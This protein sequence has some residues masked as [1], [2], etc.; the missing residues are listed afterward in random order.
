MT[1][2]R[3]LRIGIDTGGTFTDVVGVRSDTGEVFTTKTPTTPADF[4]E[5]L[6]QGIRKILSE[7]KIRPAMVNGVFHGTT[8]ATNAILERRFEDLGF[9]VT[10]GS[11]I[12]WKSAER[13]ARRRPITRPPCSQ[14]PATRWFPPSESGRRRR[15]SRHPAKFSNP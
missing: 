11:A 4:S 5:G 8:V 12:C 10:A 13:T 14:S 9:I 3:G 15:E 2:K 6:I 7:T 1:T